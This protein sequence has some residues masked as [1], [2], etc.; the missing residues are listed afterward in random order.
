MATIEKPDF[1][2]ERGPGWWDIA[3]YLRDI[4]KQTGQK[5]EVTIYSAPAVNG[6]W[7]IRVVAHFQNRQNPYGAAGYGPAY[8]GTAARTVAAACY[9]AM[10]ALDESISL[11]WL[12]E[13]PAEETLHPD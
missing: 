1:P 3:A 9:R 10:L 2:G 11:G 7:G 6:R 5:V 13:P 4:E 12:D 8:A